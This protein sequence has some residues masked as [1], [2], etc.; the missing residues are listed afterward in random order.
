MTEKASNYE[1]RI[2]SLTM[3]RGYS[4]L[5]EYPQPTQVFENR[6]IYRLKQENEAMRL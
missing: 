1:M 4:K 5:D 3:N 2:I 6:I